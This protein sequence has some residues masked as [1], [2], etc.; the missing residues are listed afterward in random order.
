MTSKLYE[1]K[2]VGKRHCILEVQMIG[3]SIKHTM[4]AELWQI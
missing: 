1:C 3:S 4:L 2:F